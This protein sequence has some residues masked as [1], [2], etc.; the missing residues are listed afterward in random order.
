[1]N[2]RRSADERAEEVNAHN[3]VSEVPISLPAPAQPSP[4]D[5]RPKTRLA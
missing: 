3:L 5:R 4:G 2:W 1:M